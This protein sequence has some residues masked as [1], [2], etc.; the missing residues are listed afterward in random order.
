VIRAFLCGLSVTTLTATG[1]TT[2]LPFYEGFE[3]VGGSP[4]DC[5]SSDRGHWS[6]QPEWQACDAG[7][8]PDNDPLL[9]C[10]NPA[11]D[12]WCWGPQK[13]ESYPDLC[14]GGHVFAGYRAGRQPIFDPYW[15]S[16]VHAFDPPDGVGDLHARVMFYDSTAIVCSCECNCDPD[17]PLFGY[18]DGR[19]NYQIQ[20]WL[21]LE[22]P[23]HLPGA[24]PGRGR[25]EACAIGINSYSS[26][27]Y[28]SWYTITDGWQRTS[29]PRSPGW[30]K[31]EIFVHPYEGQAGDVEF[32]ID[33]VT[34]GLGRRRSENGMPVPV[35]W[36]RL[37]GDPALI[38]QN[39]LVN[40]FQELYYDEMHL[41]FVPQQCN[42]IRSDF[43]NDGDVDLNDFG[44]LQRCHTGGTQPALFDATHCHCMDY[45]DDLDVDSQDAG[46][47]S[48]CAS[49]SDVPALAG[50][51][52]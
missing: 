12:A 42:P 43:D 23:E 40:T 34:V 28:Y 17:G 7:N 4:G 51:G 1:Q 13:F 30:H 31:L 50:C 25:R 11:T 15:A 39:H 10:V 20:G 3:P 18:P 8:C 5:N 33:D 2:A 32:R 41:S 45:D 27:V 21:T 36:L 37:G 19:P 14:A 47:F 26:W 38:T 44:A 48:S 16:I 35:S 49:R 29:V 9:M 46:V 6:F 22:N 24:P 52:D